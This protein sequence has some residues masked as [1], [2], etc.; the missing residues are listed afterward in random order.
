MKVRITHLDGKLPNLALMQI[1]NYHQLAGHEIYFSDSPTKDLFEPEVY[2]RVYASC[3]FTK[4]KPTLDLFKTQ[5]P[6]SIVGGTGSGT[7]ITVSDVLPEVSKAVSYEIYPS[8]ESSVGFLQRGCRMKCKFCVV[9]QKEG[10]PYY[11]QSVR[12][13]YRGEPYPKQLH[14]LD[15]DFFGVP[16]WK[17]HIRDITEGKFK[18]C[19]NQGIN[20]RL[21]ND[22]VAEA[23]SGVKYYDMKFNKRRI[24][25]A[26]DNLNHEKAFFKRVEKLLNAGIRPQHI[27]AYM[28]IGYDPSE[29][30][31]R[32]EYRAKKMIELGIKPY[33]MGL[34][35]KQPVSESLSEVHHQTLLRGLH[36]GRLLGSEKTGS[37]SMTQEQ[38]VMLRCHHRNIIETE[39][40]RLIKF[41]TTDGKIR[42]KE[43]WVPKK[44]I[45]H[46]E[47]DTIHLPAWFADKYDLN[48]F[49][50][51][52]H[53]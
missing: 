31:E 34:Q 36:V 27:M 12:E 8:F 14:L 13:L 6:D 2:D 23:L 10:K 44:L 21:I 37:Q 16:E 35:R 7:N 24:Y 15:N 1:A 17:T 3:I 49:N 45:I 28:L 18:V 9:P 53:G 52:T 48:D 38:K 40:C 41:E 43:V 29:T 42:I 33:P 51:N 22:E 25:T 26:W 19:F 46:M 4:T 50:I 39:K 11:Y 5:F 32:I 47:G 20:V 30:M